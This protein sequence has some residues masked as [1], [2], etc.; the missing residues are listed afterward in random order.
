MHK[1]A[2][3][4]RII[5]RRAWNRAAMKAW[6]KTQPAESADCVLFFS[7]IDFLLDT[8]LSVPTHT[9]ASAGGITGS[10]VSTVVRLSV[11]ISC[12]ICGKADSDSQGQN[13]CGN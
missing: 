12:T 2:V 13:T 10:A 4:C 8:L 11:A 6:K 3:N 9:A 7:G 1:L 5:E